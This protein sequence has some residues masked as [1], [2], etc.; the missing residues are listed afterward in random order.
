MTL[1]R[2]IACKSIATVLGLFSAGLG[3]LASQVVVPPIG[4]PL[5]SGYIIGSDEIF[6]ALKYQGDLGG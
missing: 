6:A 4:E 5:G 1:D 3:Y 2:R